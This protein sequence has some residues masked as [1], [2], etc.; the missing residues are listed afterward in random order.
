MISVKKVKPLDNYILLLEFNN[1]EVRYF[2]MKDYLDHGLFK[3]LKNKSV[4]NSV[5]VYYDT[6]NWSNGVDICP[7][8]LYKKSTNELSND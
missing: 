8:V 5:N 6:I 3:E 1:D 7:E 2:D 4:F